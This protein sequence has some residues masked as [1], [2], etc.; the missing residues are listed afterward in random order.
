MERKISFDMVT[1]RHALQ[2]IGTPAIA[3]LAGCTTDIFDSGQSRRTY[4]LDIEPI[5]VSP[6]EHAL[7]EPSDDALFGDPA[8][9]ALAAVLPDG[10]HTTYGYEPLSDDAYVEYKGTYY[11]TVNVTTGRKQMER[12]L[13]RVEPLPEKA[14]VPDDA[15]L[16]DELN[17]P[18][19]RVVK[20]LHSNAVTDGKGS[21]AELLREDAYVLRRP[22]ERESRL[23]TGDLDG[24][25]VTMTDGGS[26]AYRLDVTNKRVTETAHTVLAVKVAS[27]RTQFREVVF[28]SRIDVELTPE[29]LSADVQNLLKDAVRGGAY[30]ETVPLSE[31]FEALRAALKLKA[32]DTAVNG[33]L[34]WYDGK[35]YRFGLYV[36]D[37]S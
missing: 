12:T 15:I 11:Q 22:V 28:G 1:R 2:A 17:R 31:T 21:S 3:A 35:L 26:W 20:I 25:V 36:N 27:S 8:R 9:T 32:V 4:T 23:A 13:V 30:E 7:F 6:V 18:T 29:N 24:R 33:K 19:A 37:R 14:D 16:V 5:S 34:L 10:R